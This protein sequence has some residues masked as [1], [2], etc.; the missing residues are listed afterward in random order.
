MLGILDF[1]LEFLTLK[2]EEDENFGL[3]SFSSLLN[4]LFLVSFDSNY[5]FLPTMDCECDITPMRG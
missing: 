5:G 2:E 3:F 1:F 4:M